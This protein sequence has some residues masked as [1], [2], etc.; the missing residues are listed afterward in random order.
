MARTINAAEAKK[1][2]DAHSLL[3]GELSSVG[4][5]KES[6]RNEVVNSANTIV[7]RE[8]LKLL[9]QA[10]I[11]EINR[12]KKGFRIKTLRE[13]GYE[14]IADI[15]PASAYTL[16]SI[17]GI[18]EESAFDIKRTVEKIVSATKKGVKLKLSVDDKSPINSR[19]VL[20]LNVRL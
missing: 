5:R 6:L 14:T 17:N 20:A 18:S 3:M 12:E 8:T 15:V 1:L 10:P 19:L 2:I 11:D 16:A 13:S 4:R 7:T 9:R